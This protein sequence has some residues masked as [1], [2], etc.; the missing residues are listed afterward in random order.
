ML[1]ITDAVRTSIEAS[2][3]QLKVYVDS[4]A[5]VVNQSTL[6]IIKLF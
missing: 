1:A 5:N 3:I 2:E 6:K 4:L